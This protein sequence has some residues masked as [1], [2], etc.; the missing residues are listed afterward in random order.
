M[1]VSAASVVKVE[2]PKVESSAAFEAP[3]TT[4]STNDFIDSGK[5]AEKKD[6]WEALKEYNRE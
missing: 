4:P 3:I 6:K 2:E 5:K 1:A